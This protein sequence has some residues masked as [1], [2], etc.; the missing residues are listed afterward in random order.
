MQK[1]IKKYKFMRVI[2]SVIIVLALLSNSLL[3]FALDKLDHITSSYFYE[4]YYRLDV[5]DNQRIQISGRTSTENIKF[6]VSVKYHEEATKVIGNVDQ[7]SGNFSGTIDLSGLQPDTYFIYLY[8]SKN[9][10]YYRGILIPFPVVKTETEIYIPASEYYQKNNSFSRML[11]ALDPADYLSTE[12]LYD[13]YEHYLEIK[14]Q[15]E[16]IVHGATNDY[17][18]ILLIH[19]WVAENIYYDW[20]GLRDGTWLIDYETKQSPYY[21]FQNKYAV[22]QG[23]SLLSQL[24]LRSVGV[25]C[26]WISGY[27]KGAGTAPT[28]DEN[29]S[30]HAWNAAYANGRWVLFDSTW[31]SSNRRDYNEN[32]EIDDFPGEIRH[33]YFDSS[34]EAFSFDHKLLEI[35]KITFGDFKL[36]YVNGEFWVTEYTGTGPVAVVPYSFGGIPVTRICDGAFDEQTLIKTYVGNDL[37]VEPGPLEKIIIPN[38]IETIEKYAFTW[39]YYPGPNRMPYRIETQIVANDD[40]AAADYARTYDYNLVESLPL[41][42]F[43]L[44]KTEIVLSTDM[45]EFLYIST[46]ENSVF[47]SLTFTSSNSAV[48]EVTENGVVIAKGTGTA[49]I[50]VTADGITKTCEVT[51]TLSRHEAVSLKIQSLPDIDLITLDHKDIVLGAKTSYDNLSDYEKALVVNV[52]KLFEAVEKVNELIEQEN[53]PEEPEVPEEPEQPEEPGQPE[54]PENPEEP[55]E[56][57]E[58]TEPEFRRGDVDGDGNVTVVDII[59]IRAYIM[60]IKVL[61][62][63]QILA[64]DLDESGTIT[65]VDI[66]ALRRIIMNG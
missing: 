15:A 62:D 61:N 45:H 56:P 34:I 37:H 64:A 33:T 10:Y 23:Y 39:V 3:T 18:K 43:T 11:S 8:F 48:A 29:D 32:G 26:L 30:N 7:S 54:E 58:P 47:N 6:Q 21:V 42:D 41:E 14:Q 2:I 44:N 60:G 17:E 27:A 40:S 28:D 9:L 25:P 49:Q 24:M 20:A 36:E 1:H 50:T 51:V 63:A 38:S 66:V 4:D 55:E 12:G 31:D 19:D 13:T 59:S 52:E 65:V 5:L 46:T 53:E 16:E 57:E 22:C 35:E